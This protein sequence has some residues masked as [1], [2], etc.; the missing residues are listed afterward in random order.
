ML[1]RPS[2]PA[3]YET[4]EAAQG[5]F[6]LREILSFAWRQWKFILGVAG[7]VLVIGIISLLRQTPLY[8]ATAYVLLDPQKEKAPGTEAILSDVALDFA[9]V[10]SQ[11]AIIRS[12]VFLRRVVEKERL[13]SDPEFGSGAPAPTLRGSSDDPRAREAMNPYRP[14]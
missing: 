14:M 13:T 8:T 3:L 2:S 10:E 7:V 1:N 6:D 12:S 4:E 9:M 11:M 5:G